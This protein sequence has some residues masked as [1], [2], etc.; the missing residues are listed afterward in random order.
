MRPGDS[1]TNALS[2]RGGAQQRSQA[3]SSNDGRSVKSFRMMNAAAAFSADPLTILALSDN[4][5]YGRNV[6]DIAAV[7]L[8]GLIYIMGTT[9]FTD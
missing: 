4:T 9:I 3:R 5:Y 1:P 8:T 7:E 2:R 6:F